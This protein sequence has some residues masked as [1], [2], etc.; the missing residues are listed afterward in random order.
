[1]I[2]ERYVSAAGDPR[3]LK[4]FFNLTLGAPFEF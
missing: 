2:A 4:G 3:K 1:M